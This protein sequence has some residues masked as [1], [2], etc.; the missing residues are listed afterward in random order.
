MGSRA[1]AGRVGELVDVL[2]ESRQ[3][4]D[5]ALLG[6]GPWQVVWTRGPLLW[7]AYTR[8]GQLLASRQ[9]RASQDLDPASR[10]V[11]NRG[12]LLG[13]QLFVTADGSYAPQ[14]DSRALPKAVDVSVTGGALHAWGRRLPLP[15]RGKGTFTIAYL[16]DKVRLF[17]G[18]KS[19]SLQI[20]Q[21]ALEQLRQAGRE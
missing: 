19:L 10:R 20:R 16:D 18:G 4:F 13:A 9:N 14:D 3:P 7:Q 12:E 17:R 8:P 21:D 5:E 1:D 11:R 2:L 15:I 6:G